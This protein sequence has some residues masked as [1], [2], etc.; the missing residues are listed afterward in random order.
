MA[1]RRTRQHIYYEKFSVCS[2]F[3]QNRTIMNTLYVYVRYKHFGRHAD[4]NSPN[5]YRRKKKLG[6]KIVENNETHISL[7]I[8]NVG[9]SWPA[10]LLFKYRIT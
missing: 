5:I 1:T 4:S 7:Q 2:D 6:M 3:G 8:E 9:N 10:Y